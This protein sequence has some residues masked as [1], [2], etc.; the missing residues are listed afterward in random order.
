MIDFANTTIGHLEH[1]TFF[2]RART[3][4]QADQALRIGNDLNHCDRLINALELHTP[5]EATLR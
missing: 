4:V 3:E 2:A 5:G 1:S